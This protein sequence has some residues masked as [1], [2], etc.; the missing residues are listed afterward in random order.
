MKRGGPIFTALTIFGAAAFGILMFA[1]RA[2]A[3]LGTINCLVGTNVVQ[4]D[5]GLTFTVQDTT[6]TGEGQYTG[7]IGTDPAIT[8]GR[9]RVTGAGKLNCLTSD[10]S[11]VEEIRWN[12][13]EKSTISYT[14]GVIAQPAGEAVVVVTGTV[15]AGKFKGSTVASPGALLTLDPLACATPAGVREIGGPVTLSLI[16]L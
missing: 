13:G 11:T 4:F 12:T 14:F 1:P 6:I 16:S 10:G 7:C 5:P 9:S 15:T 2:S 3:A 8:S